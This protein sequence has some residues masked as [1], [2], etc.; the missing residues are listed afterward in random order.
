MCLVYVCVYV[1]DVC[2][3]TGHTCLYKYGMYVYVLCICVGTCPG[4]MCMHCAYVRYLYGM[5]VYVLGI[6]VGICM[7]GRFMYW[8]YVPI[9]V[10][11]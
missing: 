9:Y 4:S 3:G 6:S 5:Y 1:W 7:G 11:D 10:W 2:V 8:V